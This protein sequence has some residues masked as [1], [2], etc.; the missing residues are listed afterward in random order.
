M[1]AFQGANPVNVS[2]TTEKGVMRNV[3]NQM[4][5]WGEGSRGVVQIFYKGGGGHVFNV[6]RKNGKTNYIEAQTGKVKNF[7]ETLSHVRTGK[8]GLVR[9]DNLKFSDRAKNF[10]T[11]DEGGKKK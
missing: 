8:V 1:G 10:V 4:T 6:E 11:Q 2:A 5:N 9:T 7:G 3:D